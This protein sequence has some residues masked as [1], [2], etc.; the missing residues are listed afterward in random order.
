MAPEAL[1]GQTTLKSD[2]WSCGILMYY[3]F[4]GHHPFK[5][6][7]IYSIFRVKLQKIL[8]KALKKVLPNMDKKQK[9]FRNKLE[10]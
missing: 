6:N 1:K 9:H 8:Q 5:V 7:I 2:I 10:G 3:L 4:T